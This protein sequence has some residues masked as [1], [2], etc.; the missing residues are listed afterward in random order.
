MGGTQGCG[1]GETDLTG[2]CLTTEWGLLLFTAALC[3]SRIPHCMILEVP[4]PGPAQGQ[5]VA[6]S[7]ADT[8]VS[9]A[10]EECEGE[11]EKVPEKGALPTHAPR[12][13]GEAST[14]CFQIQ[15]VQAEP[16]SP[17]PAA[18]R[19]PPSSLAVRSRECGLGRAGGGRGGQHRP[20]EQTGQ[21]GHQRGRGEGLL[22][23]PRLQPGP[24]FLP[25]LQNS[26]HPPFPLSS[27]P[28]WVI[29]PLFTAVDSVAR[30][31]HRDRK[32]GLGMPRC[33]L[34]FK[35]NSPVPE[36]EGSQPPLWAS[37]LT[38]AHS[39]ALGLLAVRG[40]G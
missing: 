24:R 20:G 26:A 19:L 16:I 11:G 13:L 32:E 30:G 23:E 6:E 10:E 12:Y 36:P 28:E 7:K 2:G 33:L 1:C 17:S 5:L 22:Q 8:S 15:T 38:P 3:H 9:D 4:S 18:Q 27:D 31:D 34:V 37:A 14:G 21:K 39:C 40:E 35:E 25:S 29:I